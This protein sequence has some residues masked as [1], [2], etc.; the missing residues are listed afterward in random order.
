LIG[1]TINQMDLS[2]LNFPKRDAKDIDHE[3]LFV[4]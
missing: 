3:P 4:K 1:L 2:P